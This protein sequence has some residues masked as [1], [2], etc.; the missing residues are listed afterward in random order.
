MSIA[1]A[2]PGV[3]AWSRN[4]LDGGRVIARN[5]DETAA[6]TVSSRRSYQ[7][8]CIANM[9]EYGC[10]TQDQQFFYNAIIYPRKG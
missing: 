2:Q 10:G 4:D 5:A 8:I 3:G 7:A 6:I 1:A 9:A